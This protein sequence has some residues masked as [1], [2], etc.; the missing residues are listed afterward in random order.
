MRGAS[1]SKPDTV[2]RVR[3][4][5]TSVALAIG[6]S[7]FLIYALPI[8]DYLADWGALADIAT[9]LTVSLSFLF[10]AISSGFSSLKI[11]QASPPST[12]TDANPEKGSPGNVTPLTVLILLAALGLCSLEWYLHRDDRNPFLASSRPEANV[13]TWL[14]AD[15]Y[16]MLL[17]GHIAQN[18]GTSL[19]PMLRMFTGDARPAPSEFDA[20]A[21]HLYFVS[22]LVPWLGTYWAFAGTNLVFWWLAVVSVWWLG[23]R[24]WSKKSIGLIGA[25]LVA[26]SQGFIFMG[27]APQPHAVAFGLFGV[28]LVAH[29]LLLNRR[30]DA[31]FSKAVRFG[32]ATGSSGLIYFVHVPSLIY[33]WLAMPLRTH[34]R[35]M[36]IGTLTTLSIL[37]VWQIIGSYLG[38]SFSGG[39]SALATEAVANWVTI[40][41]GGLQNIAAWGH[42][43]RP[44][45]T[46]LGAFWYPWWILAAIGWWKSPRIARNWAMV[47]LIAAFAPALL[48][49]TRFQL[50]R[51]AF[52]AYPG[53]LLLASVGIDEIAKLSSRIVS[54]FASGTAPVRREAYIATVIS[55]LVALAT[56][57][58]RDLITG[59]LRFAV[60]FH[61]AL[62]TEW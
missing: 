47:V 2:F 21:G 1:P 24:N 17:D 58:N 29:D 25:V 26:T 4:E 9:G 34:W 54:S 35:V 53:M 49:T 27:T 5:L 55:I 44:R 6:I 22:F 18:D 42:Y 16:A 59:S 37:T 11:S 38:L 23:N 14:T 13:D 62:G 3:K 8:A 50:P 7:V 28:L 33:L 57:T 30:L 61:Y 15:G 12:A 36:V 48:F 60:N 39:N 32:W 52:F 41:R 51:V 40:F 19:L 10:I 45:G 31:S 46:M 43:S 20:R 56:V